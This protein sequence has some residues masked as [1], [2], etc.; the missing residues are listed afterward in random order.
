M[1]EEEHD[2]ELEEK[3]RQRQE[4]VSKFALGSQADANESGV[5]QE[6]D[7]GI[8]WIAV[9]KESRTRDSVSGVSD[10]ASSIGDIQLMGGTSSQGD[11]ENF[12]KGRGGLERVLLMYISGW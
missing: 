12:T 6:S 2:A 8:Q 5:W 7:S 4:M 3:E 10:D 11:S 9:S 1:I